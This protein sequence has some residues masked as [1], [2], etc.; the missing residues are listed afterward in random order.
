MKNDELI[1]LAA[2]VTVPHAIGDSSSGSVGC[3]LVTDKGNTYV[4][5]CIDTIAGM[6]FCAEHNAIGNM[7]TNQEYTIKKIVAVLKENDGQSYILH[8]CGRCREFMRQINPDNIETEVILAKDRTVTLKD[9]LP[10]QN[11]RSKV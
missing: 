4:G 5:V 7:M 8:P 2:S 6:G 1:H 10:Y 11:D 3:A 9:L